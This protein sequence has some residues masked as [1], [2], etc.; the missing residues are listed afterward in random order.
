MSIL[1]TA[2]EDKYIRIFDITTGL[3]FL[4]F[5]HLTFT[6]DLLIRPMYVL[7]VSPPGWCHILVYRRC[8]FLAC[9]WQS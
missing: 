7:H 3:L 5:E 8:W 4:F 9:V 2:H 6:D 1:V